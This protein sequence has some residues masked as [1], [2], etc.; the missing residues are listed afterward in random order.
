MPDEDFELPEAPASPQVPL[1]TVVVAGNGLKAIQSAQGHVLAVDEHRPMRRKV[2]QVL[3]DFGSFTPWLAVSRQGTT[4][5]TVTAGKVSSVEFASP[6]PNN[7]APSKVNVLLDAEPSGAFTI[8]APST[9]YLVLSYATINLTSTGGLSG[10]TTHTIRGGLGGAGGQGGQ[11]GTGGGGGQ[12]GGGGGGGGELGATP[13]ATAGT[14]GDAG[15]DGVAGG[16]GGAFNGSSGGGGQ[17]GA[18]S[19]GVSAPGADGAVGG[20]GGQGGVGAYGAAGASPPAFGVSGGPTEATVT[21]YSTVSL[22]IRIR[23][24]DSA[25]IAVHTAASPPTDT[26]TTAYIPIADVDIIGGLPSINQHWTG[27]YTAPHFIMTYI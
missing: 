3:T 7:L 12:G 11:G 6:D 23:Y 10:A 19:A 26:A 27:I 18:G 1:P 21:V 14:P 16:A 22:K 25:S 2:P 4:Q 13:A 17:G 20:G 24:C 9:V 5:V 8:S 15:D